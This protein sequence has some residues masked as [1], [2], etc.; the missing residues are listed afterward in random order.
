MYDFGYNGEPTKLKESRKEKNIMTL[1]LYIQ[2]YMYIYS[3]DINAL[4][5][6]ALM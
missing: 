6:F 2:M 3:V 4:L 1:L 5:Y